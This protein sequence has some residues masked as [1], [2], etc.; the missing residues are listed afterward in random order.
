MR[1]SLLVACYG[2]DPHCYETRRFCWVSV[3]RG[4]LLS[5]LLPVGALIVANTWA[6]V[7]SLRQLSPPSSPAKGGAGAYGAGGGEAGGMPLPLL[8]AASALRPR[9]RRPGPGPAPPPPAPPPP[10]RGARARPAR[11]AGRPTLLPL[12]RVHWFPGRASPWK[13]RPRSRCPPPTHANILLF[14]FTG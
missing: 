1:S 6:S 8:L 3:E 14:R 10:A 13:R 11:G 12:L 9:L 4:M 2:A 7:C 5:F